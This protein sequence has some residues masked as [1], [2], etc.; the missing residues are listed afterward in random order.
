MAL[1]GL[2]TGV[3]FT[4]VKRCYQGMQHLGT[5][6]QRGWGRIKV[7]CVG[8]DAT[9]NVAACPLWIGAVR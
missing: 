2:N 9:E 6:T 5:A 7:D 4:A 1:R 8:C 3:A